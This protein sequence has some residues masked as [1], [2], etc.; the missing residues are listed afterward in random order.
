[1][2]DVDNA[3]LR[4]RRLIAAVRMSLRALLTDILRLFDDVIE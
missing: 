4:A 2:R 3:L 1:M